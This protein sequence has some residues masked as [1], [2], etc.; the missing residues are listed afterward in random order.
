MIKL[1]PIGTLEHAEA[2]PR[3]GEE[4]DARPAVGE[5]KEGWSMAMLS[6]PSAAASVLGRRPAGGV[7]GV[8][9]SLSTG[10]FTDVT[11][12]SVDVVDTATERGE[13]G[14][15]ASTATAAGTDRL[16]GATGDA[17]ADAG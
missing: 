6:F 9:D 7:T 1:D 10:C 16:A 14:T 8:E 5:A 2:S 15:W 11:F 13:S 4:G 3:W 12:S 17:G